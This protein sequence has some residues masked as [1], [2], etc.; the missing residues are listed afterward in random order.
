LAGAIRGGAA[1][2]GGG[3]A[4]STAGGAAL[5]PVRTTNECPHFGQRIFSPAGGTRRSS[6]WY[7]AL[8]DS[9]STLSIGDRERNTRGVRSSEDNRLGRPRPAPMDGS[10]DGLDDAL[11]DGLEDGF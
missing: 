1:G 9:H 4:P 10:D 5:A 7:G 8:H 2:A 11:E 3:G 6:I